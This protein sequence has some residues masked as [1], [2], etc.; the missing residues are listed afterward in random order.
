ML[1]SM[2]IAHKT[3]DGRVQTL[4]E[5]AVA[6]AQRAASFAAPFE[7]QV[8]ARLLGLAHDIGKA[9]DA[10][11]RR[12]TGSEERVDHA[13]AGAQYLNDNYGLIG[14]WLAYLVAGHHGGMPN[15]AQP[16]EAGRSSLCDRLNKEV[17]PYAAFANEVNL[18]R[19]DE[20]L[21]AMPPALR[22][23][24]A[25]EDKAYSV[26]FLLHLLYSTLVDADFLDTEACMDLERAAVRA[27]QRPTLRMLDAL[28]DEHMALAEGQSSATGVNHARSSIRAACLSKAQSLPGLYT[29]TV[30]TGAGKTLSSLSFALKHAIANGQ[31]RVIY[32][33][34]YTSIVE[35]N[36]GV[37]RG[38][39]GPDAV[40][41]HH[42]N[43]KPGDDESAERSR[44]LAIENWDAPIVVTTNVQLFESLYAARPSRARKAHNMANSVIVLDE[45]QALPD[46]F[47]KPCLA[48]LEE[49]VRSCKSTVVLCSATQPA[50]GGQWP[51]GSKPQELVS[52]DCYDASV[53]A[54]RRH[55]DVLGE[56]E[57]NDLVARIA[58]E[59]QVLCIVSSRKAAGRLY[60]ELV[61]LNPEGY[62][63]HLSAHMVP[64][65]RTEVLRRVQD[66]L[67]QR[68]PC[69]VVS[70][71][72]IEAGVDIDFPVVFR[73]VAGIDSIVQAAGRCNREGTRE[74]GNVFVFSCAEIAVHSQ[75]WLTNMRT[76]GEEVIQ[77]LDNPFNDEGVEA[78]FTKRYMVAETD[79]KGICKRAR[80]PKRLA[81]ARWDFA[82]DDEEFE[83]IEDAGVSLFV[84]WN[85]EARALLERMES[86]V[87]MPASRECQAFTVSVPPYLLERLQQ[88]G[89]VLEYGPYVVLQP[90]EGGVR[91]YSDAK[92]VTA[93]Q[94][95]EPLFI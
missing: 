51:G 14:K 48:A 34:P 24:C 40:L 37:L 72:L 89:A 78:F 5:H 13:T 3:K 54:N 43:Y 57:L 47:L 88:Q 44:L 59:P 60:D 69:T 87:N 83:L 12:I 21:G 67:A 65:H 52:Q 73:E 1:Y 18:P 62:V 32:A 82:S 66:D 86:D 92:G 46:G 79:A 84:P 94:D 33:I 20:V 35:Q 68:H 15:Y 74:D 70:T 80:E 56:L 27:E 7:A 91:F 64:Q 61:S 76:L 71:Q 85:D 4:G 8:W 25:A 77:N 23:E 42:S 6:V 63:Y 38:I 50:F 17:E 81:D 75:G 10:F 11:Q 95:E 93:P 16:S 28:L 29:L 39:F 19:Y 30:P 53:F 49:L 9:S 36:A 26:Y 41:E 58:A 55:F 22:R 45:A 90:F 2:L 31:E